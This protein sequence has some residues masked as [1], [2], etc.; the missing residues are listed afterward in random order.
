MM[1]AV[2]QAHNFITG[3]GGGGNT[4]HHHHRGG[5][6]RLTDTLGKPLKGILKNNQFQSLPRRGRGGDGEHECGE[7]EEDE[8]CGEECH[9]LAAMNCPVTSSTSTLL[10]PLQH[11]HQSCDTL[12]AAAPRRHHNSNEVLDTVE[13]SV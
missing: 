3:R 8:S 10:L 13:S 9:P 6:H 2:S 1:Q 4:D 5:H 7:E 12:L 11:H